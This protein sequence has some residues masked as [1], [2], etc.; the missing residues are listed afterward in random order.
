M[1]GIDGLERTGQTVDGRGVVVCVKIVRCRSLNLSDLPDRI[2]QVGQL[3]QRPIDHRRTDIQR[4]GQV[5]RIGGIGELVQSIDNGDARERRKI[6][7][8][9]QPRLERLDDKQMIVAGGM[10]R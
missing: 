5:Q 10:L 9:E 3:A 4:C 6:R 1:R 2:A 7:R 8:Q